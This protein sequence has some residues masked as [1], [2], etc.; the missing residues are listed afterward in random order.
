MVTYSASKEADRSSDPVQDNE[1]DPRC[2]TNPN[3][4][5]EDSE[6]QERN[7]KYTYNSR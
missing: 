3:A 7:I 2:R 5:G 6:A 4:S 1:M